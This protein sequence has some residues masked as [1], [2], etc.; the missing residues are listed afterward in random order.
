VIFKA[1][2]EVEGREVTNYIVV[3]SYT[4]TGTGHAVA[5]FD[6][7]VGP[8]KITIDRIFQSSD[9]TEEKVVL[10]INTFLGGV[11][12]NDT[13]TIFHGA[14]GAAK[15]VC[16]GEGLTGLDVTANFVST[17]GQLT[18]KEEGNIKGGGKG[19]YKGV[20]GS[21]EGGIGWEISRTNQGFTVSPFAVYELC[22]DQKGG[23]TTKLLDTGGQGIGKAENVWYTYRVSAGISLFRSKLTHS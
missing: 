22:P 16:C 7:T 20:E 18:L 1:S 17:A 19:T 23:Y 9:T 10:K 6:L 11:Y 12:S 2:L 4:W 3:Y 8:K 5:D 13:A 21:L 15:P 14:N